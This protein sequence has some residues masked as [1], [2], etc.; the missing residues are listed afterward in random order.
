MQKQLSLDDG[1][2]LFGICCLTSSFG[3]LFTFI[4][5]MYLAEA[6]AFGVQVLEV[7]SDWVQRVLDYHKKTIVNCVLTWCT[8][9]SV[10]F[11]FLFLFKRLIDRVR[12]VVIYWWLVVVFNIAVTGYGAAVYIL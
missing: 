2:L 12:P 5:N 6:M 4:D 10:K 7:P 8:I 1:F 9:A 3:I 11:S